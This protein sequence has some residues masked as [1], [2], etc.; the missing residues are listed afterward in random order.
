M[1]KIS[2]IIMLLALVCTT[3][4]ANI[5]E[6]R[7][8]KSAKFSVLTKSDPAKF[9]VVYVSENKG[10]VSISIF[11]EDGELVSI[12][13]VKDKKSFSKTF[14]FEKLKKGRYVFTLEN[15]EGSGS[16]AVYYDP[17]RQTLN[18]LVST[19]GDNK[20]KVMVAGFNP[21]EIVKVRIYNSQGKIVKE[22]EIKSHRNFIRTYDLS[23]IKGQQF[24]FTAASGR[25]SVLR[26]KKIK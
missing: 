26:V 11:D 13:I 21:N 2:S 6:T 19:Q 10:P 16:Q 1:K 15:D 7:I 22:D 20:F 5:I 18:M 8:G 17:Y 9:N 24:T 12:D 25:E 3:A 14:D 23:K 4:F